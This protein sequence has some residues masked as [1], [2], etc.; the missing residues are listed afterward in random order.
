MD[1][2]SVPYQLLYFGLILLSALLVGKLFVHLGIGEITGQILGGLLVNPYFLMHLGLASTEYHKA[3]SSFK[4]L[5]FAVFSL[6]VFA[7]GEEMHIERIKKGGR[8]ILI[9]S[10][11]QIL[12]TFALIFIL[13]FLVGISLI[14]SLIIGTVGVAT[15]PAALFILIKKMGV[16]GDLRYKVANI[17]VFSN[18][19]QI[20]MFS[21]FMQIALDIEAGDVLMPAKVLSLMFKKIGL[22][23]IIGTTIFGIL[24]IIVREKKLETTPVL[25]SE[26]TGLG[27]LRFIFD[28]TPTPS[29]EIFLVIFGLISAGSAIAWIFDLPFLITSL[30]AGMLVANFHTRRV[31]DSLSV[32]NVTPIL[33]LVF[34]A[35]VGASLRLDTYNF[36]ILFY[37]SLYVVGRG[38]GKFFGTKIGC[39]VTKQDLK[40]TE[41]LP[42]L[43]L[44]QAGLAAVQVAFI[45]MT[46]SK[47]EFIF[48][49]V[50]PAM[51]IFEVGGILISEHALKRW[52]SWVIG[53]EKILKEG[54]I[55]AKGRT[56]LSSVLKEKNIKIPLTGMNK[57]EVIN[58]MLESLVNNEEIDKKTKNY[59]FDELV[60]REKIQS[61]GIGDGIAIPHIRT[62][63]VDKLI[64]AFGVKKDEGIDFKSIDG[65]PVNIVFLFLSPE[66]ETGEHLKLLSEV[67]FFLRKES[68]KELLKN[69]TNSKKAHA[70][71]QNIKI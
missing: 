22:A 23:V 64:C 71:F 10:L 50:I 20:I 32:S 61:T 33:N 68:N 6:I 25:N 40:I 12:T 8:E 43:M 14:Y 67:S 69:I 57:I 2:V 30:T 19:I 28:E 55:L 47:G 49:T 21:I 24:K 62:E 60:Q 70:F 9:I 31:F 39:R 44:P 63:L 11:V 48:Q 36:N 53:E 38:I 52:K 7:L 17:V 27:F 16:E 35:L 46:L 66:E 45:G 41:C 34:F 29:L 42:M 65:K 54:G 1:I 26:K 56:L 3:F 51:V 13:F 5:L 18:V 4:F 59:L 37:V 15:A 58:E